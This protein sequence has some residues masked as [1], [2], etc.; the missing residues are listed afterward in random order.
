MRRTKL[1][2]ICHIIFLGKSPIS[3][4]CIICVLAT[5]LT[6]LNINKRRFWR[7]HED[8][9]GL[10]TLFFS[11]CRD[12]QGIQ[13]NV[14]LILKLFE[15]PIYMRVLQFRTTLAFTKTSLTWALQLENEIELSN[16]FLYSWVRTRPQKH[17]MPML[18]VQF[19]V[20]ETYIGSC[21]N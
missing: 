10:K 21:T 19:K 9:T 7:P 15:L 13:L 3:S 4:D 2:N 18:V 11:I 17:I 1:Q 6:M 12:V 5:H 20:H 14:K 16:C 8:R